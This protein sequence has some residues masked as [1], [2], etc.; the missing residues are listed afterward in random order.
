ME[1]INDINNIKTNPCSQ[2]LYSLVEKR[3][4]KKEFLPI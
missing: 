1:E 2:G 3:H 4:R